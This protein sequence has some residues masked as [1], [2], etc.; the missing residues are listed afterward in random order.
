MRRR[1]LVTRPAGQGSALVAALA[2][3]G[4]EATWVPTVAIEPADPAQLAATL[5]AARWDWVIVT[6]ANGVPPLSAALTGR[7][8]GPGTRLAAVGAPTAAALRAAGLRVDHVPDRFLT[9][10]I[11]DG[12]GDVAGARILLARADAAT[13]DLRIALEARGALVDE[14]VAYHTVEGPQASL[15]AL[16]AALEER[17]DAVTFTSGSTARGLAALLVDDPGR[18]AR[19]RRLPAACIGPVTAAE[20]TRLG[21]RP[22]VVATTHTAIGLADAVAARLVTE[23]TA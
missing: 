5:A 4:I 20:A 11:A 9:V 15:P 13:P 17:L 2:A 7:T 19:A 16:R 6:S 3:R 14:T 18:L 23:G 22:A 10:A 1:L 21:W 8:L 12:L